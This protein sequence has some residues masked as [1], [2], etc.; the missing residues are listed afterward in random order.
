M[1]TRSPANQMSQK[2]AH[3]PLGFGA[4]QSVSVRERTVAMDQ[5]S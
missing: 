4:P 5:V 1:I 3:F 2:I